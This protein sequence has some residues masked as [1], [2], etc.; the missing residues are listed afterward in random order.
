MPLKEQAG[1]YCSR[2]YGPAQPGWGAKRIE[3][4]YDFA[5][6]L[7]RPGR[8]FELLTGSVHG[9]RQNRGK[10]M[11]G[12]DGQQTPSEKC[13]SLKGKR[14]WVAG[15]RG[16]VGSAIARRLASEDCTILTAERKNLDFTRQADVESWMAK[17]PA[18]GHVHRRRQGGRHTGQQHLPGRVHLFEPGHPE[19][20]DP[21]GP[22]DGGGKTPIP[23]VLLHIPQVRQPPH[24][25]GGAADRPSGAHQRVV[26]HRQDRGHQDVP[27][28]PQAVRLRFHLGHANQPVRPGRQ[29]R[30]QE[31]PRGGRA[32]AQGP[33]GQTARRRG[34][35]HLGHRFAATRIFV[36]G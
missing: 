15:H 33:R 36:C 34:D 20:P 6:D 26:C 35:G 28:L 8:R 19:Q 16:M 14:V 22:Q 2:R 31:R 25:R 10:Q 13:Y 5:S 17:N 18:P 21:R 11:A 23:R 7:S 4:T 27:G 30:P 12:H 32:S 24:R 9:L 1:I 3:T 29:L